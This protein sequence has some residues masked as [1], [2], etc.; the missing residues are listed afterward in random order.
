MSNTMRALSALALQAAAFA[1]MG[2]IALSTLE[3]IPTPTPAAQE[4]RDCGEILGTAFQS[5]AEQAWFTE[6]CSAWAQTTL[7]RIPNPTL[8]PQAGSTA[9]ASGPSGAGQPSSQSTPGAGDGRDGDGVQVR[10]GQGG[11]DPDD[12]SQR[13]NRLRGRPYERAGDR[14][15]FLARCLG[16]AT[17]NSAEPPACAAI[18]GRSYQSPDERAWFLGNCVGQ[19]PG[20][21]GSANQNDGD[22][23]PDGE[24]PGN[25]G[26]PGQGSAGG[27]T[28]GN[29]GNQGAIGPDGRPCSEIYGTRY[30]SGAER[31][32][33]NVNCPVR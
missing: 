12:D 24:G 19:S 25:Q 33:F 8:M 11:S 30:R 1:T 6:N 31:A 23:G 32:W 7:G 22:E 16:T 15:W 29:T 14:E 20:N 9:A 21:Q 10:A 13:C 5:S 4:R 3:H 26:S 17:S 2:C 28:S 27:N 18:R